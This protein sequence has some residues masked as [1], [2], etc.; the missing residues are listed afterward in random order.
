MAQTRRE[1]GSALPPTRAGLRRRGSGGCPAPPVVREALRSP[2]RPL[3]PSTRSRLEPRFGH[4]FGQVRVHTDTN[5]SGSARAVGALAYTVGS[6][7]VFAPGRY[8][9]GTGAGD[10]LLAHELAHVVQQG[11]GGGATSALSGGDYRRAERE[12]ENASR[13]VYHGN[14]GAHAPEEEV[15]PLLRVRRGS[16]QAQDADEQPWYRDAGEWALGAIGGEFID[17]PTF[18]Q[19][20]ADFVLSVI[21]VV[22]Q[23]ADAR[24]LAAHVY[25]LGIRGEHNRW[26][27]W[28]ALVFSLVG[29]VPEVGS[30]IKSLSK[31]ALRG[32]GLV[33]ENI[34]EILSL[35]RRSIPVDV[36]DAGRL[37]RYVM[38]N[39][40]RFVEL[41][42]GVWNS[43]LAKGGDLV[44]RIPRVVG[45]MR[46][47][48][49]D[50]LATLRRVSSE[51][52]PRAFENARTAI[53]DVLDRVRE[54]LGIR[55]AEA[56]TAPTGGAP[57]SAADQ[58]I[59]DALNATFSGGTGTAAPYATTQRLIRGNLGERLA[60]DAL[61]AR[62]H[63][64]LMYKPDIA[65]TNQG[66]IDMVTIHNGVVFLVDNKALTRS[67]NV[68]SVS[69]LTTNFTQNLATVRNQIAAM[70]ADATRS[71]GE[72]QLM[73]QALDALNSGNFVRAVTNA[74]VAPDNQILSGITQQLQSLG[75]RFIDVVR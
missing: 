19:I 48:A 31:A 38:E 72:R 26:E 54:R 21:P 24:D 15:R 59:E 7:V 30:V 67:G 39:W 50:R 60:T 3:D 4:D 36:S 27:R 66:G 55:G 63:S 53:R 68:S 29:L 57:L 64:V 18:G 41:G 14:P 13:G 32:V 33:L 49:L 47:A 61:A 12:A 17:E 65:G 73:Q 1:T 70:A 75:L 22:D 10:R 51:M 44:G 20:G 25:R 42:T 35:A 11:S 56:P 62:G 69:A 46:Q 5:A 52:L 28:L 37:Q 58:Q 43:L 8:A 45:S 2:G 6:D 74:N 9:P 16:L 34:G 71:A 40:P 23:A